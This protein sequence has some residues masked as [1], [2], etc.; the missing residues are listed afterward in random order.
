[1]DDFDAV[2]EPILNRDKRF[3]REAY[4][5]VREALDHTH[6]QILRRGEARPRHVTGQELLEGIRDYALQQFGPMSLT[7]LNEWGLRRCEDFGEIVFLL[8]DEKVLAKT[9]QDSMDDFR[10]GYDFEDAF[11]KPFLPSQ[12]ADSCR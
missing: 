8:V 11:R 1:M 3:T 4:H 6:R 2:L 5:F 9:E 12:N 10:G 7:V